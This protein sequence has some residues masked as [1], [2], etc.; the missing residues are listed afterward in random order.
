MP[1]DLGERL[2]HAVP[3]PAGG[4]LQVPGCGQLAETISDGGIAHGRNI[5]PVG[6]SRGETFRWR[7]VNWG[8]LAP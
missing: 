2:P 4:T 3:W 5:P 6:D 8:Y 1:L 7:P